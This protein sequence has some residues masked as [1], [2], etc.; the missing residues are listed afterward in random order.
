MV[1]FFSCVLL[2]GI[3]AVIVLSF[4]PQG[5]E[6][7]KDPFFGRK[8]LLVKLGNLKSSSLSVS[9]HELVVKIFDT[10][11][12]VRRGD[13]IFF[14][15]MKEGDIVV[16]KSDQKMFE[17]VVINDASAGI[18]RVPERSKSSV[19]PSFLLQITR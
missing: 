1:I 17:V 3:L 18:S 8:G 16:R 4:F 2:L 12:E 6:G 19:N 11:V 15:P 10:E 9:R 14:I 13:R 7:S 5:A